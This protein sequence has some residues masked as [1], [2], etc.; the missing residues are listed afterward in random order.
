M[1][2]TS[3]GVYASVD[4]GI[5]GDSVIYNSAQGFNHK[6][7]LIELTNG[8]VTKIQNVVLDM[9]EKV[10]AINKP[11]AATLEQ[12]ERG[13]VVEATNTTGN[14]EA[15]TVVTAVYKDGQ[16]TEVKTSQM[17]VPSGYVTARSAKNASDC[18]VIKVMVMDGENI[19]KPIDSALV[20]Q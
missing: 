4:Y 18:D 5:S 11:L 19:L 1:Q 17:V 14:K 10:F 16:M 7:L 6:A 8:S 15:V 9:D 3:D 20:A 13:V 12:L 2:A